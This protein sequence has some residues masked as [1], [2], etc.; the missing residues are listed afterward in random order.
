MQNSWQN[1]KY[2]SI[3]YTIKKIVLSRN[4]Y[5][6]INE[7]ENREKKYKAQSKIWIKGA[8]EKAAFRF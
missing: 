1:N 5:I 8:T 6:I 2:L 3:D 7:M 4:K